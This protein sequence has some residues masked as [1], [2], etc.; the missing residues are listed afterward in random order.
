MKLAGVTRETHDV[1]GGVI[2]RDRNANP[3]GIFKH[4]AMG[5]IEKAVPPGATRITKI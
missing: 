5:L 1:A 2:V 3:T 4:A